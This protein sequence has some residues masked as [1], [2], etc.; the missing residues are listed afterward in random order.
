MIVRKDP[1]S[2]G[3]MIEEGYTSLAECIIPVANSFNHHFWGDIAALMMEYF[4]GIRL[5][6][7]N[8]NLREVTILPTFPTALDF[9]KATHE[10]PYGKVSVSWMRKEESVYLTIDAN[11]ALQ[12]QVLAPMGYKL[13]PL[14]A[15]E[16]KYTKA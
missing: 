9:A 8:Y 1:P 11:E 16:Y 15:S 6:P 2:Y 10:T 14:S 5:N 13:E 12:V 4:V 7:T 3:Y